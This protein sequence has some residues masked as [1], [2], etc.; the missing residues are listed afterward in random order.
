[1]SE[2][3]TYMFEESSSGQD[4]ES[5]PGPSTS[6]NQE[7]LDDFNFW[8]DSYATD[9]DGLP[10]EKVSQEL[11]EE[12]SQFVDKKG[13]SGPEKTVMSL[14][15]FLAVIFPDDD[16]EERNSRWTYWELGH[17]HEF[18]TKIISRRENGSIMSI[19]KSDYKNLNKNDIKDLCQLI[20]NDK[21]DEYDET[22]LLWSLSIFIRS[23]VI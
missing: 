11:V 22:G 21:V 10:I 7:Q 14:H 3:G 23:T 15:K 20:V 18:I 1:M 2:H 19:T 4:N 13:N 8:M 17:E 5:E 12:M 16:I 9:D 6:G